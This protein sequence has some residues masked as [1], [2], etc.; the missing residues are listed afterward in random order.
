MGSN[1]CG[2]RSGRRASARQESGT[3][4]GRGCDAKSP[5][6]ISGEVAQDRTLFCPTVQTLALLHKEDAESVYGTDSSSSDSQMPELIPLTPQDLTFLASDSANPSA[7]DRSGFGPW[8]AFHGWDGIPVTDAPPANGL[9]S[10]GQP[11]TDGSPG[12]CFSAHEDLVPENGQ[13]SAPYSST[14]DSAVLSSNLGSPG[15]Q[16][17]SAAEQGC[18]AAEKGLSLPRNEAGNDGATASELPRAQGPPS[19]RAVVTAPPDTAPVPPGHDGAPSN[20]GILEAPV[21]SPGTQDS[22]HVPSPPGANSGTEGK[23]SSRR[24]KRRGVS[25][26]PPAENSRLGDEKNDVPH[27]P[28]GMANA[29]SVLQRDCLNVICDTGCGHNIVGL[30]L[31][32]RFGSPK[33]V[34]Q[35]S[36][37]FN[38]VGAS[39]KAEILTYIE[40]TELDLEPKSFWVMSLYQ[41]LKP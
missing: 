18:D 34:A 23:R 39:N 35:R 9:P 36:M 37:V 19:S 13:S 3:L 12:S 33:Y 24:R 21:Q 41:L 26:P 25:P 30:E 5:K 28:P 31:A 15:T 22:A 14:A 20:G 40:L 27:R 32:E 29:F 7:I 16:N 2:G 4:R 38:G 1:A 10:D 11:G 17:P 6:K 8:W